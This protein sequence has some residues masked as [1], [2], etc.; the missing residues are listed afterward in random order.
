MRG[1][2]G[3][4]FSGLH[5]GVRQR[6]ALSG[7]GTKSREPC[8]VSPWR[9][10]RCSTICCWRMLTSVSRWRISSMLGE[11]RSPETEN[12]RQQ[13]K[14]RKVKVKEIACRWFFTNMPAFSTSVTGWG[15]TRQGLLDKCPG[16][17][18]YL[19]EGSAKRG[20]SPRGCSGAVSA[21]FLLSRCSESVL[22]SSGAGRSHAAVCGRKE[23]AS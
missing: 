4:Q 6:N 17:W 18:I 16:G 22:C 23:R 13:K 19:K 8:S 10:A 11:E 9:V 20:K 1:H 5:S 14:K 3:E 2:L 7:G 12:R 15:I 21:L